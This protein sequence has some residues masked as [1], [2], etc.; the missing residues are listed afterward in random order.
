MLWYERRRHSLGFS[1]GTAQG[2]LHTT[3]K[4]TTFEC[5]FQLI[6]P[7]EM[8]AAYT[9]PSPHGVILLVNF[10]SSPFFMLR[11]PLLVLLP[12]WLNMHIFRL[13][14]IFHHN[15]IFE[16]ILR[17]K[18]ASWRI[19]SSV[20]FFWHFVKTNKCSSKLDL[21]FCVKWQHLWC[22]KPFSSYYI[23]IG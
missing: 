10:S 5:H 1:M 17:W 21:G 14:H 23:S 11:Y 8:V 12:R 6:G 15:L 13:Q 7:D 18:L 3:G 22:K 19:L 4:L 9:P 2:C 16:D 20:T